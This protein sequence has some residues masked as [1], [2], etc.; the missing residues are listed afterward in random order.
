MVSRIFV[1]QNKHIHKFVVF[2]SWR[3]FRLMCVAL[4]TS[5]PVFSSIIGLKIFL[6]SS[7]CFSVP[8]ALCPI[9]IQT[10]M[11]RS[12]SLS[13][14]LPVGKR[15]RRKTGPLC[16]DRSSPS[17]YLSTPFYDLQ[18]TMR[19]MSSTVSRHGQKI[20]MDIEAQI[21]IFFLARVARLFDCSVEGITLSSSKRTNS[22]T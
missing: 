4:H 8:C 3:G 21:L 7:V 15:S 18:Q 9:R 13:P 20:Y 1:E 5:A 17:L 2:V 11:K 22:G 10:T 16:D 6:S 14:L 19:Q 12:C